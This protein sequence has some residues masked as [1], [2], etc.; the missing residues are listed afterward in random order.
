PD[1]DYVFEHE[2]DI[3]RLKRAYT[4]DKDKTKDNEDEDEDNDDEDVD[5]DVYVFDYECEIPPTVV[6]DTNLDL[7]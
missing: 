7:L 4:R 3:Y 5:V 2:Q 6:T 1:W